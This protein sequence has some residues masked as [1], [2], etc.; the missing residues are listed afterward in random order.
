MLDIKLEAFTLVKAG[1]VA[2]VTAKVLGNHRQP[3]EN[4][5]L[6]NSKGTLKVSGMAFPQISRQI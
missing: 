3:L 5:A 2:A 6:L 1:Q 4:Q